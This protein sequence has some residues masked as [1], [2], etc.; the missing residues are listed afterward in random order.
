MNRKMVRITALVLA[1]LI[2]GS[3]FIA[4][5]TSVSAAD[6]TTLALTSPDTGTDGIPK[7]PVIIGVVSVVL[8][9]ACAVIPKKSKK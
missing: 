6:A 3:V 8:A 2:A 9:I 7:T 1:I 4:A 5:I